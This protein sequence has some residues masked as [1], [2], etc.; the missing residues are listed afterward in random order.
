[1]QQTGTKWIQ[2]WRGGKGHLQRIVQ[3]LKFGYA[4]NWYMDMHKSESSQENETHKILWDFEIKMDCQIPALVL[5]NKERNC[6]LE[7][8]EAPSDNREKKAKIWTNTWI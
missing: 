2:E 6:H 5:I 3:R 4:D 1:M 8:F 7:D